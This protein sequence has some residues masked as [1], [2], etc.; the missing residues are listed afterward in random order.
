[1]PESA[2]RATFG[3]YNKWR[4]E[5]TKKMG[6][7]FD[8]SKVSEAEMRSLAEKMFQAAKVPAQARE[9]YLKLFDKMKTA[10]ERQ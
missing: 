10:L 4:A 8:W 2:H 5:M 7:T 9:E 1:V 3:V 6:G